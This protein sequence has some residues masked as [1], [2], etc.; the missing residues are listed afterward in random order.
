MM[1]TFIFCIY[2]I[3]MLPP[4]SFR[5]TL[6]Q[7]QICQRLPISLSLKPGVMHPSPLRS[8]FQNITE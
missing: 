2:I 8:S 7:S 6:G 5:A 4:S 1:F 3:T